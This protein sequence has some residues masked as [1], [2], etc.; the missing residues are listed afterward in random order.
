MRDEQ[1]ERGTGDPSVPAI[2]AAS[3]I[4]LRDSANGFETLLL[5]RHQRSSFVPGAWV[6]PGGA[7]DAS[8]TEIAKTYDEDLTLATMKVCG[9]RELFEETGIWTGGTLGNLEEWR[10]GLLEGTRHFADLVEAARPD[11]E[12]LVWTSRWITPA[13]V[14]KRFDTYFFLLR[15]PADSV[16]VAQ[17]SEAVNVLWISPEEALER[18]ER[19]ELPMVFPTIRNL[20]A[21]CGFADAESLVA[22]RTGIEIKPVQPILV[23]SGGTKRLVV[24]GEEPL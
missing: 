15:V 10:H 1:M 23:V 8:D 3:T 22:S 12:R 19:R 5:E 14:P 4:L 16:A 21:I 24:P 18:E 11:L 7:V 13:D 17:N 20:K 2:P 9:I 6:F